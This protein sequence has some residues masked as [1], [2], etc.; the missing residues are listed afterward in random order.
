MHEY[1]VERR[2]TYFVKRRF[3][4]RRP[5]WLMNICHETRRI[6]CLSSGNTQILSQLFEEEKSI[7]FVFYYIFRF[8]VKDTGKL[9]ILTIIY[10]SYFF[11]ITPYKETKIRMPCCQ[12]RLRPITKTATVHRQRQK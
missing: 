9:Y 5:I 8:G 4:W 12:R 2:K 11:A 6:N 10:I 7:N 3:L 1:R